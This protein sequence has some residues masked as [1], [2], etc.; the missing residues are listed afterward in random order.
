MGDHRFGDG[1]AVAER[2]LQFG[3]VRDGFR[4]GRPGQQLGERALKRFLNVGAE[5]VSAS[6]RETLPPLP[7]EGG[8]MLKLVALLLVTTGGE[9]PDETVVRQYAPADSQAVPSCAGGAFIVFQCRDPL[10]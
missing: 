6:S 5:P 2:E 9:P 7:T 4:V 10:K 3:P 8:T 1:F